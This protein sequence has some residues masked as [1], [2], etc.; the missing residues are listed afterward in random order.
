MI[1]WLRHSRNRVDF[2]KKQGDNPIH[3][4]SVVP[5]PYQKNSAKMGNDW[6]KK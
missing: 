4:I 6:Q 5:K 3:R 2:A 1:C